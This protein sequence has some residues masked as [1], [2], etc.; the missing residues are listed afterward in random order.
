MTG[1]KTAA[2][3][4]SS[5]TVEA[6]CLGIEGIVEFGRASLSDSLSAGEG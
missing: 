5:T 1:E 6:N 3:I 2:A 4:C